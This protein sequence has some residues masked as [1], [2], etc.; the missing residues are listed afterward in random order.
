MI[1]KT[2]HPRERSTDESTD[3]WEQSSAISE[4]KISA[5]ARRFHQRFG[6]P[7]TRVW[8][9]DLTCL[10]LARDLRNVPSVRENTVTQ[11]IAS[12]LQL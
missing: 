5:Q 9:H 12:E 6:S 2:A 1:A 11:S 8:A 10:V 4:D 7:D 3:P